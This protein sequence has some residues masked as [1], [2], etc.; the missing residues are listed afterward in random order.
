[1]PPADSAA[2]A[3]GPQQ[4]F[5]EVLVQG[6][7][8]LYSSREQPSR[9]RYF[10]AVGGPAARLRELAEYRVQGFANGVKVYETRSLYRDTLAAALRGCL[11][12]QVQLPRLPFLP[13]A[14]TRVVSQYNSCMGGPVAKAVVPAT[15]RRGV[16]LSALAGYQAGSLRLSGNGFFSAAPPLRQAGPV[17]GLALNVVLPHTRRTVNLRL[18]ALYAHEVFNGEYTDA[19]STAATPTFNKYRFDLQYLHLPVLLRYTLLR[20]PRLHPF[21]EAGMLYSRLLSSQSAL[22]LQ[23]GNSQPFNLPFFGENTM[24]NN[25]F[26]LQAGAGLSLPVMGER[27]LALLARAATSTGP[28][29][30][31]TIA[32]PITYYSV[33]LGLDLSKP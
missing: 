22:S 12:V 9:T 3:S 5:L 6:A 14:L 27:R 7:A 31:V 32:A 19:V 13:A 11:A 25:Q 24:V 2:V 10:V 21:V 18:E 30:Y 28:S 4:V 16:V 17:A 23:Q 1:V 15:R 29:D 33:L 26:G 20:S 8:Q